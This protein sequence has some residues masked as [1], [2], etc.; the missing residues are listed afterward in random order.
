MTFASH[1]KLICGMTALLLPVAASTALRADEPVPIPNTR[2]NIL[3]N[4]L[5]NSVA[6]AEET[7]W[8]SR[9]PERRGRLT[10]PGDLGTGGYVGINP[11]APFTAIRSPAAT[12]YVAFVSDLE[13]GLG[14]HGGYFFDSWQAI[15]ARFSVGPTNSIYVQWQTHV[16]Y[17]FFLLDYLKIINKG[18]YLGPQLRLW[19]LVHV[20][21]G[22]H[23]FSLVPAI[24]LGY[25]VEVRGFYVDVRITQTLMA[26]S[27]S[28]R[29][30]TSAGVSQMFS[31]YPAVS[32]V[33]PLLGINLGYRFST[34]RF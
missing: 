10:R 29:P 12:T 23:D 27:W 8:R 32:P 11:I 4:T 13:S 17:D 24:H 26:V 25:R 5:P 1:R 28:N 16:S 18:L 15:D 3:P 20:P 14:L 34:A 21:Y 30:A 7:G 6:P 22:T 33:I 19:D 9:L 2:P 31:V